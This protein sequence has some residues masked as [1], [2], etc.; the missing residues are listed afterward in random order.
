MAGKVTLDYRGDVAVMTIENNGRLNAMDDHVAAGLAACVI[1]AKAR[2]GVGALVLRGAGTDAFCSGVDLKFAAE[3]G[4]RAKA[5]AKVG[6]GMEAFLAGLAELPFPSIALV[7]GVCYGGGVHLAV[8]CDFRFAASSLRLAIPAVKNK[9][10]YPIPALERLM[11]LVGPA[12]TRRLVLE[13]AAL[14]PETL[15]AWG[16]I[17]ELHPADAID[18]AAF[19]F[20]A[21]LAA[22]PRA[23][24]PHY[25]KILR[26]LDRDDAAEARRLREEARRLIQ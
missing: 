23:V 13:G 8:S 22:Q 18:E 25:M 15:L 6:A 20:A 5:F 14:A 21:R 7:H 1:E 4:D 3:F 26:A 16:L 2:D 12:R 11:R 9:L 17:D 24:V 19:A 10:L